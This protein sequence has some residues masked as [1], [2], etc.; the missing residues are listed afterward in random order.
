MEVYSWEN[1]LFQWAIYT[2]A[3]LVITIDL[4]KTTTSFPWEMI[5]FSSDVVHPGRLNPP[6]VQFQLQVSPRKCQNLASYV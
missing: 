2:M 3:M 1:H 6:R 5:K 4:W